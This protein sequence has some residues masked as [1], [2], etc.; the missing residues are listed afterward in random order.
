LSDDAVAWA[1]TFTFAMQPHPVFF[2][3]TGRRWRVA[4]CLLIVIGIILI[5]LPT[6][7]VLT[8]F[9]LQT[10]PVIETTA[11]AKAPAAPEQTIQF[12]RVASKRRTH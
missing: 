5:S 1:L 4:K 10:G 8:A 3:A 9:T 2:D 12:G 6:A 11:N 7:F